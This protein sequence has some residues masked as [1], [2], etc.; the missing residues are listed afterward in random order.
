MGMEEGPAFL[1]ARRLGRLYTPAGVPLGGLLLSP[2]V[3]RLVARP[4]AGTTDSLSG[5]WAKVDVVSLKR[6][7][8]M[9]MGPARMFARVQG[10]VLGGRNRSQM[11]RIHAGAVLAHM[12]DLER[13]PCGERTMDILI[14]QAVRH[15]GSAAE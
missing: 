8:A 10:Y 9:A 6:M 7:P 13:M 5:V 1:R 2:Y 11:R 3:V 12:V 14:A 4:P 15:G